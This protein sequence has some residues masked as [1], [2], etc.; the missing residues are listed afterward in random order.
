MKESLGAAQSGR[1][2]TLDSLDEVSQEAPEVLKKKCMSALGHARFCSCIVS[3][4]VSGTSFESY[5]RYNFIGRKDLAYDRSSKTKRR[6]IDASIKARSV[7]A[8][9]YFGA[10]S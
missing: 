7:C 2:D 3:N 6:A 5:Y 10:G 1:G 4:T 9:R 8:K